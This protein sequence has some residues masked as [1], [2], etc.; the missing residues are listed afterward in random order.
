MSISN[1]LSLLMTGK[2]D[3]PRPVDMEKYRE[4]YDGIRW[5]MEEKAFKELENELRKISISQHKFLEFD[6]GIDNE[7]LS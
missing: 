5:D 6:F 3:T 7:K 1:G 2:G 4:N